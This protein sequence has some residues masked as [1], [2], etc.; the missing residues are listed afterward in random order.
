MYRLDWKTLAEGG[1]S[2]TLQAL[3]ITFVFDNIARLTSY[4]GIGSEQQR[5]TDFRSEA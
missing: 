4:T 2:K 1:R 3:D 5:M